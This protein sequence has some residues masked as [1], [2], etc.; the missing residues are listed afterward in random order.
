MIVSRKIWFG[1]MALCVAVVVASMPAAGAT[2]TAQAESLCMGDDVGWLN[3]A[4]ITRNYV[5]RRRRTSTGS[6][7]KVCA[8]RITM[9]KTSST[10]GRANF[11]T[12][13]CRS[14][15]V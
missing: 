3:V 15:L 6:R 4:R 2:A 14:V 10:A 12:G 8:S 9:L 11:V 7:P 5:G 13:E 1:L